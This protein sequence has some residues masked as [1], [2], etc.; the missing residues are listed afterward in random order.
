MQTTQQQQNFPVV[1]SVSTAHKPGRTATT[2]GNYNTHINIGM[3][4]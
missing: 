3:G 4:L 2:A 1:V